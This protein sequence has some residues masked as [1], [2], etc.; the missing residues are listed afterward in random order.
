MFFVS[1]PSG[2]WSVRVDWDLS[3]CGVMSCTSGILL[4]MGRPKKTVAEGT[5]VTVRGVV[6]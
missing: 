5:L 1:V 4:E 2:F 6:L 3:G